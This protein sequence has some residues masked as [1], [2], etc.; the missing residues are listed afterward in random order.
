MGSFGAICRMTGC[1]QLFWRAYGKNRS[2]G[3][4]E[5]IRTQIFRAPSP[6]GYMLDYSLYVMK[7]NL[8]HNLDSRVS[9]LVLIGGAHIPQAYRN[10]SPKSTPTRRL[11]SRLYWRFRFLCLENNPHHV[12]LHYGVNARFRSCSKMFVRCNVSFSVDYISMSSTK[13]HYTQSSKLQLPSRI[14]IL[15]ATWIFTWVI[16]FLVSSSIQLERLT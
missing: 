14:D 5:I 10:D 15:W 7:C 3:N 4:G 9:Q 8:W 12:A 13:S 2:V 11:S 1:K 6:L 16:W